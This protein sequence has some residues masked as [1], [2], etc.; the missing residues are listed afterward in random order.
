MSNKVDRFIRDYDGAIY[1]VSFGLEK[2][3]AICDRIRYLTG[4][5]SDILYAFAHNY[6]KIKTDSDDD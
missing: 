2:F 4:L 5:K 6:A 1:L 3:D